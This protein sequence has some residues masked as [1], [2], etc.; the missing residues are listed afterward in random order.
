MSINIEMRHIRGTYGDSRGGGGEGFHPFAVKCRAEGIGVGSDRDTRRPGRRAIGLA[1]LILFVGALVVA[2]AAVANNGASPP[3]AGRNH[4]SH[5]ATAASPAPSSHPPASRW[6]VAG[7]VSD[8]SVSLPGMPPV[9]SP[10]NIY[11]DDGAGMLSPAARGVPYRIYV[12]NSGGST[13]TVIDPATYRV[14]G[15]FQTG[16]NPQHVVPGYDL[17]TLYVTNDLDN[18]LTPIS[19]VTGQRA[20]PNIP[21][22]DP[23]NMYFTPN[24]RYAIV[25]AEARQALYFRDPHTFALERRIRVSC[26]GV[27]HIDFAAD[28]AYLIATCEFAGRLV[29]VDL[30]TLK[31]AGYLDLP[32]SAPQDIKLDPTGRTFYVADK[33]RAGVWMIDAATFRATGFLATGPDAHG[34]YP[35]RNARDLYVTNRGNGSVSVI[36]FATKKIVSTWWIPGGGS[37]D[38]GGVSPDGRVLWLSGRYDSV[39]Y[40]ISTRNGHLLAEIPVGPEPHG[41]CVWPQP[42]R[43][44]LG[45]T[46]V[47]R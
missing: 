14:I 18:S 42:G 38:M 47:M 28:G 10:A 44:S 11:A 23:Y 26:A 17:R 35:S 24:G 33:N 27:D 3:T 43:Y 2:I 40:A 20:G 25:V 41:L 34:L 21:V 9:A 6:P 22:A 13:V 19:P 30:H 4:P 39:V 46:G 7:S 8:L 31:V 45:H 32:G 15:S 12:P 1:G 36:N 16:F 29:R 5:R 37:P